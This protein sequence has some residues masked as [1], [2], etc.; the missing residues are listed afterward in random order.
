MATQFQADLGE[1]TGEELYNLI[2]ALHRWHVRGIEAAF[3]LIARHQNCGDVVVTLCDTYET[4]QDAT[5]QIARITVPV[6]QAQA[7]VYRQVYGRG[8]P[9]PMTPEDK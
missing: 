5:M 4:L 9:V 3:T 6:K 8:R 2:N 7:I 1:L